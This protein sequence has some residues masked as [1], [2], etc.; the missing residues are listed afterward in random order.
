MFARVAS[1]G[2]DHAA[3]RLKGNGTNPTC[4]DGLSVTATDVATNATKPICSTL[5]L[6]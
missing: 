4:L 5:K 6:A 1:F 3:G 2:Y